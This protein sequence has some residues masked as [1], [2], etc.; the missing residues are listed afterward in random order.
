MSLRVFPFA[1][2]EKVVYPGHGVA[3]VTSIIEKNVA[4]A[5]STF[6]ELKLLTKDVTVLVPTSNAQAIGIRPL[7]SM[8]H[9]DDIFQI[10]STPTKKIAHYEFTASTWNKRNKEY[11]LKL[12]KGG[13]KELSEIYRDLRFIETQK[14]LSFGEKNLL[15][16]TETLLVEEIALVHKCSE[17]EI[18]SKLRTI[19]KKSGKQSSQESAL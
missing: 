18:I 16:Q 13:L 8:H 2:H 4:G 9:I 10:L 14:E 1:L 12:G 15:V 5:T 7:S 3:Q 19:F 6:Y 11:K 17:E